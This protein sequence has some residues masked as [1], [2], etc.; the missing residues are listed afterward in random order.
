[1]V[2]K[3]VTKKKKVEPGAVSAPKNDHLA[4]VSALKE[5]ELL[6]H[7]HYL[8]QN[9][10]RMEQLKYQRQSEKLQHEHEQER[11]RIKSAEIR[12]M[13]E[14]KMAAREMRSYGKDM[15]WER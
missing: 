8:V 15:G 10:L 9:D 2:K 14:R 4:Y 13:Q 1:M 6:K 3:K 5:L 12:K 7:Q 11:Q